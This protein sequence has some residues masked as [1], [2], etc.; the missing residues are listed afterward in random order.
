MYTTLGPQILTQ[1]ESLRDDVFRLGVVKQGDAPL[2]SA[3]VTSVM[4]TPS[5]MSSKCYLDHTAAVARVNTQIAREAIDEALKKARTNDL[6]LWLVVVKL[7]P[8]S[9]DPQDDKGMAALLVALEDQVTRLN[10]LLWSLANQSTWHTTDVVFKDL[11][12]L[13]QWT[14]T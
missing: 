4:D 1:I 10:R 12:L 9:P 5:W 2:P 13:G 6:P 7:N 11:T 14:P 8:K 3:T